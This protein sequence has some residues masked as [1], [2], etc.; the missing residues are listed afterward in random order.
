MSDL[1]TTA[2]YRKLAAE[3]G[4]VGR[5]KLKVDE[6]KAAVAEALDK[7]AQSKLEVPES[8]KKLE[9]EQLQE[10]ERRAKDPIQEVP[11]PPDRKNPLPEG[12][13]I[14][15]KKRHTSD[16]Q[17]YIQHVAKTQT[18][19]NLRRAMQCKEGYPAWLKEQAKE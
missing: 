7:K 11:V 6:L 3:L 2:D 1:K 5:T 17:R 10:A 4:I 18:N 13:K 9:R 14:T 16:W 15:E 19:G 8:V 12:V